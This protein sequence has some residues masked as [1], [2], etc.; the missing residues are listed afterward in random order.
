M[1]DFKLATVLTAISLLAITNST[2]AQ[3]LTAAE[4]SSLLFIREEEKLARDVYQH[5]FSLWP[6]PVF[7][8]IGESEQRHMDAML[9]LLTSFGLPDPASGN[10]AGVFSNSEIQLLYDQLTSQGTASELAALEVGIFIEEAD[11]ADLESSI[12]STNQARIKRVYGNLLKGS[13]N[14]LAAFISNLEALGGN[15]AG[16]QNGSA[17][18]PGTAVYEPISQS[19]YIPALDASLNGNPVVVYD[20]LLRLVETVPQA[21]EVVYANQINKQTNSLLHARFDD[22]T[23]ILLIPDMIAGS[24]AVDGVN[25]THYS[26]TLQLQSDSSVFVVT[27]ITAK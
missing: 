18:N 9:N 14:H 25:D 13:N 7:A 3:E 11:I 21:L 26:L 16:S 5:L 10:S 23:G 17:S 19:L 24:L 22:A 1:R 8:S 2:T 6:N 27:D 20:A 15:Y 4:E 12:A